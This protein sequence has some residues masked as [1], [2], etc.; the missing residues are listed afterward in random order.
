MLIN[1]T[2]CP[3]FV[4]DA[5]VNAGATIKEGD[6]PLILARGIKNETEVEGFRKA[7]IRDGVAM[8]RFL[9]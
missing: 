3:R 8:V 4:Y 1:K 5:L 7:H 6:D 9:P 2:V